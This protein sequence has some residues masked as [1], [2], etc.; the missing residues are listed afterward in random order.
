[1]NRTKR[2]YAIIA[3]D[4][5]LHV[6]R[7]KNK[8][9]VT[10][11]EVLSLLMPTDLTLTSEDNLVID[12]IRAPLA[13]SSKISHLIETCGSEARLNHDFHILHILLF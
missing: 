12:A 3:L 5:I 8:K 2:R 10:H 9:R 6:I 4:V 13:Y 7:I 1:M 11:K